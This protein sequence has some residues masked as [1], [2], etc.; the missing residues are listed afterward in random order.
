[1]G[2]SRSKPA[3]PPPPPPPPPVRVLSPDAAVVLT[4]KKAREKCSKAERKAA[5]DLEVR[6]GAVRACAA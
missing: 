2:A 6:A 5:H 1:M 4:L 3:P